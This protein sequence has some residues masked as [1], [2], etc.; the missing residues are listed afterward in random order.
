VQATSGDNLTFIHC[1]LT[2]A[3]P[4][5]CVKLVVAEL[6]SVALKILGDPGSVARR[7]SLARSLNR[8]QWERLPC[9]KSGISV[10]KKIKLTVVTSAGERFSFSKS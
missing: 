9:F 6:L 2:L 10:V 3:Y 5:H 1:D 4:G 8:P 7:G